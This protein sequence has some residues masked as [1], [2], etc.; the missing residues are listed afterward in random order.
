MQHM[1]H[2]DETHAHQMKHAS[3]TYENVW[4]FMPLSCLWSTV[5]ESSKQT[6]HADA[7]PCVTPIYRPNGM[8]TLMCAQRSITHKFTNYNRSIITNVITSRYLNT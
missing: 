6:V 2:P 1:Q 3:K 7:G 5:H 4:S 8:H